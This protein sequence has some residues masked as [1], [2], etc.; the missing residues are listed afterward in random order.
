MNNQTL[1]K[2]CMVLTV[3]LFANSIISGGAIRNDVDDDKHLNL[4]SQ[5]QY[6]S[7]ALFLDNG[8][9]E[10][11]GVLIDKQWILTA[12]HEYKAMSSIDSA[13]ILLDGEYFEIEKVVLHPEYLPT[14]LGHGVDLA[15][16]K[17]KKIVESVQPAT[18]YIGVDELNQIGTTVGYGVFGTSSSAI[19][20]P[21]PAGTKRAGNNAIDQIGGIINGRQFQNN[22]LI[23]DFDS[24]VNP[25]LNTIGSPNPLPLEYLPL[26]GDS[27][28]LFIDVN[29]EVFLARIFSALTPKI[30]DNIK[31]GLYGS[32]AYWI[33]LSDYN[34]WITTTIN[35]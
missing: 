4:G 29:N 33:R 23:S 21:E 27:G 19:T 24:P 17:L 20:R 31:D 28:G 25:S 22:L 35:S 1:I 18:L 5:L 2:K 8:K 11:N 14:G 34:E 13:A 3:A 6:N 26:G 30:N 12:G 16:M 15:L 7:V 9:A 32:L 10:A